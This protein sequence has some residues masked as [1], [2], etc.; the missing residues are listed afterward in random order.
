MKQVA[1]GGSKSAWAL[2]QWV[3]VVAL[4]GMESLTKRHGQDDGTPARC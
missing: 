3:Q 2:S 4:G 1:L